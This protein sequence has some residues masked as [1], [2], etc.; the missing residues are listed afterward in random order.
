VSLGYAFSDGSSFR[1]HGPSLLRPNSVWVPLRVTLQNDGAADL[2][3]QVVA[4]VTAVAPAAYERQVVLP[5]GGVKA[6][7]LYLRAVD[8]TAPFTLS[9][10]AGGK[11]VQ[12]TSVTPTTEQGLPLAVGVLSDD[13]TTRAVFRSLTLGPTALN[14]ATLGG[15]TPLDPQAAT[16][17][18]FDL[19]VVANYSA[20]GLTS[21]QTAALRDWVRGGGVLLVAG[22]PGAQKTLTTLS[23]SLLAVTPLSSTVVPALPELASLAGGAVSTAGPLDLPLTHARPGAMIMAA[24][25]GVPLVADL[26]LG[27]GHLIYAA[28]DPVQAPLSAWP[29]G[30]QGR[31]WATVLGSALR[32]PLDSLLQ[33]GLRGGAGPPNALAAD[34]GAVPARLLPTQ[35]V[36][37]VLIVAYI[38]LLGPANYLLLRWRR[39]LE[40]S[41]VTIP[42]LA[43]IFGLGSFGLAYTRNGGDVLTT[44]DTVLYLDPGAPSRSA[45][46][47]VGL[48][49]PYRGDYD[50]AGP[51]P[52]LVWPAG[53]EA[54]GTGPLAGGAAVGLRVDE[55]A[56]TAAHLAGVQMWS[57]RSVG[58]RQALSVPGGVSGRLVLTGG[59]VA[60]SVTN[61][62]SLALSDCALTGEAGAGQIIPRLAPG[63][64]ARVAPFAPRPVAGT[65]NPLSLADRYAAAGASG[66][67]TLVPP[68]RY[69]TVLGALF[70]NGS[71]TS[72]TSPLAL[73]CWGTEPLTRFTIN[74]TASRRSD[75]DLFVVPLEATLAQGRFTVPPGSLAVSMAGSTVPPA[76]GPSGSGLLL[77]DGESL[78]VVLALPT[79]GRRVALD[80]LTLEISPDSGSVLSQ[81]NVALWNWQAQRWQPL[82]VTGGVGIVARAAPFVSPDGRVLVKLQGTAQSTLALSNVESEIAVG[83]AG[84]VQ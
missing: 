34:L 59:L 51:V 22:G 71:P 39:R 3:V 76:T 68:G 50:L 60:G 33:S 58:L 30:A 81:G 11:V 28:V 54:S 6:I 53:G 17:D 40:W 41:W 38:L 36:Y 78:E 55:G 80:S 52:A 79:G 5:A 7:T 15:A 83:A 56:A 42:A 72:A 61:G 66:A 2:T 10:L 35:A 43:A 12:A 14:V 19:I 8:L 25:A 27:Q 77:S 31:F 57:L 24:H 69:S 44:V 29:P 26:P 67:R 62:T 84:R 65:A 64:T 32:G 73:V 23:P 4:A 48:H 1:L 70:P 18:S 49:T 82:T 16:L 9:L 63:Q 21:E 74:G 75:L 37:A 46:T 20:A 13:P 47:Y 45:D